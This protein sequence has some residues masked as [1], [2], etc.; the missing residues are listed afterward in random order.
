LKRL[1]GARLKS[2][3]TSCASKGTVS[4]GARR[5]EAYGLA[6]EGGAVEVIVEKSAATVTI[7]GES[8]RRKIVLPGEWELRDASGLKERPAWNEG[9]WLL[10]HNDTAPA[11]IQFTQQPK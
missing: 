10:D 2:A 9:T 8:G 1:K 3:S 11:R 5:S 7:H 6:V 4:F